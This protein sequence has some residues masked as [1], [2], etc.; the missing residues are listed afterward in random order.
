[1]RKRLGGDMLTIR[2]HKQVNK[3]LEALHHLESV[4]SGENLQPLLREKKE[5]LLDMNPIWSSV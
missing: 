5:L 2:F 3:I 1:M 4:N